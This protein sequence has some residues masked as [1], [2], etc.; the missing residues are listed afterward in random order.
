M[1]L[2]NSHSRWPLHGQLATSMRSQIGQ[3]GQGEGRLVR[4]GHHGPRIN[5][6]EAGRFE[7]AHQIPV[8]IFPQH[9]S[10]HGGSQLHVHI[11]GLNK[12]TTVR[13]GGGR[14][15]GH[16]GGPPAARCERSM[17]GS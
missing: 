3:F 4:T 16:E 10:R 7:D 11:L 12:V 8:A 1:I 6:V 5:G 14:S 15:R 2:A 13:D 9:I 17:P